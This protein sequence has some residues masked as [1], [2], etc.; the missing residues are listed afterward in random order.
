MSKRFD[1]VVE[2]M[3]RLRGEGGCPWDRKQTRESLKPYLIEEAYEVLE[4]IEAQDDPKLKEELGDVLLQILFHAE[5]GRERRTFTIEDVLETLADKLVRRHPHVFGK[6]TP[7]PPDKK[8]SAEEVV[9]RWE[10]IKRQE[11]ADQSG[12]G[13]AGSALDDVPKALPALLRA[14][15]LQ[16]RAA[17]VGFD[18]PHDETGYAQVV[19]KVH[20]ELREVEEARADVAQNATA[21]ARQRLQDEVGDIL[22]ALVNLARVVKVNPEEALRGSANRFAARFTH[23]EQAA[24]S[25]G[26]SLHGMTLAE[27]ERLW[28]EAKAAEGNKAQP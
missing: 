22:F 2:I 18:W 13:D 19:D 10:E 8:I 11:K 9:H 3:S 1:Q 20:E 25:R 21:A 14:Y 6:T 23:M 28:D 4:T 17:R 24:K 27:M 15:Q 26:R 12:N 16:V 5:I 7:S